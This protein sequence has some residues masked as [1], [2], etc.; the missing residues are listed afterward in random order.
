MQLER[1]QGILAAILS[2]EVY[3]PTEPSSLETTGLPISLIEN[4]ICKRLSILG[5]SSG[6]KL[7]DD[8]CLPFRI[9]EPLYNSL[10][11]RQVVVHRG[12]APLND[13]NYMLTEKGREFAHAAIEAS[14]YI[15]PAPV[16]LM[17]YVLSTEAQTLIQKWVAR[18]LGQTPGSIDI[19]GGIGRIELV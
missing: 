3:L 8:I 18:G 1:E 12:S 6:R 16:P 13:Y 5:T 15:G 2:D 19:D 4:L 7:A 17:D 11:S 9:L 10:R 14:A